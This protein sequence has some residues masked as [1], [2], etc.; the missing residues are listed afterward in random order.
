[1][2]YTDIFKR[3]GHVEDGTRD[4]ESRLLCV[5]CGIAMSTEDAELIC[6]AAE[7]IHISVHN[8]EMKKVV[9]SWG[10]SGKTISKKVRK[11]FRREAEKQAEIVRKHNAAMLD[12]WE[13]HL[14]AP[15]RWISPRLWAWLQTFFIKI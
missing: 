2:S 1:M 10:H 15:P 5:N 11:T 3:H 14:K 12:E 9:D 6:P 8:E 7:Y 4:S 13:N